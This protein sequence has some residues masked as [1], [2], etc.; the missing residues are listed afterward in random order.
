[1]TIRR[2]L[3]NLLTREGDRKKL[4][5]K[6]ARI[7]R[8]E[9]WMEPLEDRRLLDGSAEL[10]P[11][12]ISIN[13]NAGGIFNP[14]SDP[15]VNPGFDNVLAI[16]PSQLTFRF[17]GNAVLDAT[18]L[19]GIR[20][21][22][23]VDGKWDDD[24]NEV[25]VPGFRGLGET[26]RIVVTRF[27]ETLPDD[28]YRI[29]I[30]GFDDRVNGI[31]GLRDTG[32][33]LFAPTIE[34]TD[35]D[36]IY[37]KLDLGAQ[38]IAVVPQP[39]TRTTTNE[40]QQATDQIIVYFN[41]DD[42]R[43]DATSA[44]NPAFYQL[45]RT[46]DT[47]R[48]TDDARFLPDSV[49]YDPATDQAV[50]T[51]APG[52]LSEPGTYRLRIG[53]SESIPPAPTT[54]TVGEAGSSFSTAWN[55]GDLGSQSVLFS[56][57]INPQPYG[58]EFPGAIDEPGHRDIP[59]EFHFNQDRVADMQDG[60][61]PVVTYNFRTDY[62]RDPFGVTLSNAITEAQKQRA[63]E[64]FALFSQYM[65]VQFVETTGAGMTSADITIATGDLRALNQSITGG[66]G[67]PYALHGA[68][69]DT[70]GRK[71]V[72]LD[73]AELWYDGFGDDQNAATRNWFEIA[74]GEIGNIIGETT[75]LYGLGHTYDLPGKTLQ[76]QLTSGMTSAL[77]ATGEP[78]YPGDHDIVHGQY[79]FKPESN[80]IDLYQFSVASPGLF[81]VETYA[82]RLANSSSLDTCLRLYRQADDGSWELI[83]QDD[84]YFSSDSYIEYALSAGTY[85]VGV[86]ASGN[87]AYDP[88]I[89]NSGLGGRSQGPY[90][91]RLNFRPE[92][93]NA[94]VDDTGTR[95]DGDL[96]GEPGGVYNFWF[97][98]R[99]LERVLTVSWDGT[100][101]TDGQKLTLV[102]AQGVQRIFEFNSTG[103]VSGSNRSVDFTASSSAT[104]I[105][106]EL[107]AEIN[108][109]G[110]GVTARADGTDRLI[111]TG[112]R[113]ITLDETI[114]GIDVGG[115]TIFVDKLGSNDADGSLSKPFNSIGKSSAN[116][117]FANARSGDIVRIV[118]NG[119][120]DGSLATEA[121]SFAYEIGYGGPSGTTELG[122]G[123]TMNVPQ[124][125]TVMIDAGAV[126]KLSSAAI[127]VGSSTA[128]VDRSGASI[129]VL[130]TPTR[131]VFFTSY[132]NEHLGV[133]TNPV[134]TTPAAGDWGG[135][136][137]RHDVDRGQGRF[138]YETQ[139][140]FLNYINHADIRY[141]G[142]TVDVDS[143]LQT[144][145]PIRLA[146]ARP[147]LTFN[148]I[149]DSGAAAIS[150]D[151]DSFEE[152]NFHDP[153]SQRSGAFTS[154]HTRIGPQI[155]GN[156]LSGN[157]TNG[158]FVRV[159]TPAGTQLQPLTVAARFDDTDIPHVISQNLVLQ[160]TP[161]GSIYGEP[162][163]A[164]EIVTV[165]A[166]LGGK[167]APG[168]YDYKLTFVDAYGNES[169][170]SAATRSATVTAAAGQGSI[171]LENLPGAPGDFVARRL[172]RSKDGG[173]YEF[174]TQLGKSGTFYRDTGKAGGGVLGS[175]LGS[176][177]HR[178]RSDARLAIDPGTIVKL[179]SSRIEAT[180]GTQLLAEGLDGYE[181]VFTSRL[182]DRYGGSGTFDTNNDGSRTA[183][184]KGNWGGLF[185]GQGSSGSIDHALFT[186]GGGVTPVEGNFAGFN[187][188]EIHQADVRLT[189]SVIETNAD[190]RGGNAPAHRDGRGFNQAAAIFVRGAQPIIVDNIIR[191]NTG[192]AININVN[193]LNYQL[194][195]DP[196]R[197]TGPAIDRI[198]LYADNQGPLVR[199]NRLAGNS[200]NG[201]EVRGG[202]LTTQGVWDDTDITHVLRSEVIVP[203]LHTYG[204]LRLE[205]SPVES[206]VVKL[207]G[208]SAGFTAT[209]RPLDIDDRIGGAVYILGQPGFPVIL[210]SLSDD[211]VGAG[212]DPDGLPQLD[213]NGNG[214][215]S[216]T[217]GQWRGI[218]IDEFSHD[219]NVEIVLEREPADT[220]APGINATPATA[221]FLGSLAT[222]E[223]ANDDNLRLGFQIHGFLSEPGDIDVFSFSATSGTEVWFDIDRTTQALDT[224]VELI[225][226]SGNII[227]QTDNSVDETAGLYAVYEDQPSRDVNI[228]QNNGWRRKDDYTINPRDAGFRVVLP[229]TVGEV[230]TFH[231]RLRSSNL[232][233]DDPRSNL[234]D[235]SLLNEG[236]TSGVYQLQ[237]RLQQTDETPGSTVRYADIRFATVAI[238]V[239]GMPIH[240]PLLGEAVEV[241]TDNNTS[242]GAQDLG[243][244]LNTDKAA[245]SVAGS[246]TSSTDVDFYEFDVR[247]DATEVAGGNYVSTVFDVDYADG[248]ARADTSLWVFNSSGQLILRAKD[249]NIAEDRPAALNGADLDDLLRGSVGELDPFIGPIYLREGTYQVVV[250]SNAQIPQVMDQYLTSAATSP[251]I[252]LEPIDS[253]SRIAEDRMNGSGGSNIIG[254][255][256]LP[257]LFDANSPLQYHLGDIVL[258]VSSPS[259]D[260]SN[261]TT[262]RTVNPF[263]GAQVTRL[264]NFP[265]TSGDIAMRRETSDATETEGSLFTFSIASGTT[266]DDSTVQLREIDTGT[267]A[268]LASFEDG[269]TTYWDDITQAG[270]QEQTANE[271]I[272][273]EALAFAGETGLNLYAVGYRRTGLRL[274][275]PAPRNILYRFD[276]A[277]GAASSSPALNRLTGQSPSVIVV[278][279]PGNTGTQIRERGIIDT[280]AGD[281]I[282]GPGGDV[283]GLAFI[284]N[285][286]YAVS[287][288][289]GLYIV[290]PNNAATSYVQTS[291]ADLWGI[292]FEGLA[293]I[294]SRY[295]LEPGR[296]DGINLHN[297]LFAIDRRGEVYA[298]DTSGR[299]QAVF[300]DSQTHVPTGINNAQGLEFSTLTRNLWKIVTSERNTDSGHGIVAN[301]DDS[302]VAVDGN[303]SYYFGSQDGST[304]DVSDNHYDFPGGA[305]GTLIS[306]TF[307][308]EGYSAADQPMLYFNYYL[309]SEPDG[310]DYSPGSRLQR[311]AF[312]VYISGDDGN[313][314]LLGTND[315]F[316][317]R[318]QFDEFDY[319]PLDSQGRTTL[320]QHAANRVVPAVYELFQNTG[321]WRQARIPLVDYAGQKNLRLRFDFSTAGSMDVG[322]RLTTGDELRAVAGSQLRDGQTFTI[323]ALGST[324]T[325]HTFEIDLGYTLVA[326]SGAN[327]DAGDSFT[328]DP[329]GS[330]PIAARTFTFVT[331]IPGSGQIQFAPTDTPE[332]VAIRI[333]SALNSAFG[334][335]FA[336]RNDH[337]VNLVD[338]DLTTLMT[339]TA[340]G[341]PTTQYP[342]ATVAPFVEGAPD[343]DFTSSG[344]VVIHVNSGM[345]R[346]Q[347]AAAIRQ[348]L[349]DVYAVKATPEVEPN[350]SLAAAQSIE[351]AGLWTRSFN[352]DIANP[353]TYP[354]ASIAGSGNGSADYYRFT[355]TGGR[356]WVDLDDVNASMRVQLLD[357]VG[358]VLRT[359]TVAGTGG[360]VGN[361]EI[362]P[363]TVTAGQTYYVLV[364]DSAGNPVDLGER[365]TLHVSLENHTY[366]YDGAGVAANVKSEDDLVRIIK[367]EFAGQDLGPIPDAT[368]LGIDAIWAGDGTSSSLRGLPGDSFGAFTASYP[369]YAG[370]LRGMDNAHQGVWIDDVIIGLAERGEM[371]ISA[372]ANTTF[373]SNQELLNPNS[374]SSHQE[375]LT[376]PYQLEI[377]RGIE[378]GVW[379]QQNPIP[380]VQQSPLKTAPP[381]L[382]LIPNEATK[383]K[384]LNSN[385]RVAQQTTLIASPGSQI[386]DG[387]TFQLSDGVDT[388]V[389]EFE[390]GDLDNGVA[391]GHIAVVFYAADTAH[392]VAVAVR[393]A[394]N[395]QQSQAKLNIVASLSDGVAA[396]T[397]GSSNRVNLV[398]NAVPDVTGAGT[399][400]G[401]IGVEVYGLA[402]G[403]QN[404]H[405]YSGDANRLR[406]QGQLILQSNRIVASLLTGI[407]VEA[408]LRSRTDLIPRGGTLPHP[409]APINYSELNTQRLAPGVTII[410][411]V[412]AA[413]GLSGI[414]FRGDPDTQNRGAVPFGRVINNT[415]YGTG[416]GDVGIRVADQASPTLMNNILS[417]L[418]TGI[419]IDASSASTVIGA[420]LYDANVVAGTGLG[421]FAI[422]ADPLFAAP[423]LANF[424]LQAGSLAIDSS[425]DSLNDRADFATRVKAPLGIAA[426]P[427]L[428][429]SRDAMGQLRADDPTVN[430]AGPQGL[431]VFKDRGALDRADLFGPTA[432]LLN[433]RDNDS[434]G[435]DIDPSET[436]AQLVSGTLTEFSLVL[437]DGEGTGPDQMTVT[438]LQVTL[439]ED[440]RALTEG[441][442]YRYGFNPTN[443]TI[444]LTPLSG[445]WKPGR[446]YEITLN[447]R[448]RFVIVAPD[449]QT[450]KDG[451]Q[452]EITDPAGSTVVFEYESG[453]SI[454][455]PE[456]LSITIPPEGAN[457]G[458]ITDGATFQIGDGTTTV[459]FEFDSNTNAA[460]ANKVIAFKNGD[461]QDTLA[462]LV[463]QALATSGLGLSPRNLGQGKVHLGSRAIHSLT[464]PSGSVLT[465]SGTAA[466][467]EDKQSFAVVYGN[468]TRTFEFDSDPDPGNVTP[469]NIRIPFQLSQTHREIADT[470]VQVLENVN[471][472]VPAA[473]AL[474]PAHLRDGHIHLAGA[475]GYV[476]DTSASVVRQVRTS[477]RPGLITLEIPADGSGAPVGLV[478]GDRIT[479]RRGT[480]ASVTFEFDS[481]NSVPVGHVAVPFAAGES[482]ATIASRLAGAIRNNPRLG[483]DPKEL[484]GGRMEFPGMTHDLKL[485]GAGLSS[486]LAESG[487]PGVED[488]VSIAVP[489]SGAGLLDGA[490]FSIRRGLNPPV[491]FEFNLE[492]DSNWGVGNQ[493]I[494]FNPS[495]SKD[496]IAQAIVT[497]INGIPGLGLNAESV[498]DSGIVRLNETANYLLTLDLDPTKPTG[499]QRTGV[500]GGAVPVVFVPDRSFTADAMAGVIINAI[501]FSD[502]TVFARLRAGSTIFLSSP[503]AVSGIPT[504]A[505]PGDADGR[506][507]GIKDIAGNDLQ[508]NRSNNETQF[509]IVLAGAELD[510]GD[511]PSDVYPSARARDGARHVLVEDSVFLGSAVT[512]E[513]DAPTPPGADAGDD[514]VIFVDFLNAYVNSQVT[515]HA[516]GP[517]LLD[518]WIDYNQNGSWD[519]FGEKV[520]DSVALSAGSN[521]LRLQVPTFAKPGDTYA[522]FRFSV[523][524]GLFPTGI[525]VGGEVE[526]YQVTIYAGTP[527]VVYDDLVTP[528]GNEDT[529]F[530]PAYNILSNDT[531][532][533]SPWQDL[534]VAEVN[535][536]AANVGTTIT[537][538]SGA[539]LTVQAD[540]TFTFD[541]TGWAAAQQLPDSSQSI[542]QTFTYRAKDVPT[543]YPGTQLLSNNTATVTITITGLNDAPVLT[544]TSGTIPSIPEDTAQPAGT[545]VSSVVANA[546]TDVDAG[547]K[548]GMAVVGIDNSSQGRWQYT[549][550]G[551]VNWNDFAA[552]TETA[553][554]LLDDNA[555]TQIRFVPQADFNGMAT[556]RYRAW[557]QTQGT[558]GGTGD[559]SVNGGTTAFSTAIATVTVTVTPVND[560]PVLDNS[561]EMRLAAIDEDISNAANTGT[562][563]RAII[564][565]SAAN[566]GDA[567]TD[568]D[569]GDLEGI[570][571][572]GVDNSNGTWQFSIDGGAIWTDFG[573][574][575]DTSARLLDDSASTLV[576]FVPNP[577]FNGTAT[578]AL[579]AWDR[580]SGSNGDTADASNNGGTTAFSTAVET[581]SITVNPV[582]D[583]P[584]AADD[585]FQAYQGQVLNVPAP[586]VLYNDADIDGY[587]L[588]A[589]LVSGPAKG[590]LTLDPAGSFTY[591]PFASFVEGTDTFTYQAQGNPPGGLL[592]NVATVTITMNGA[593]VAVGE[594]YTTAEDTALDVPAPGIL[595][596]D[597]DPDNDDLVAVLVQPPSHGQ[598]QQ[599]LN[600]GG[601][602]NGGF[603]YTPNQ[604]FHGTDT[605]T[606]KANDGAADSPVAT[607]TI[608]VSPVNDAPV[609]TPDTYLAWL[610]PGNRLQIAAPGVLGNDVDVDGDP[611]QARLVANSGPQLG[612]LTFNADGSFTYTAG[613]DFRGLDSFQYEALDPSGLSSGPVL[614]TI[615]GSSWHN[616]TL[617]AD[618]NGDGRVSPID[619]LQAINRLNRFGPGPLPLPATPPPYYDVNGDGNLTA[620]DAL[621][622]INIL[623]R[624]SSGSGEGE[625]GG[626]PQR[627]AAEG[628]SVAVVGVLAN[629]DRLLT[630]RLRTAS[631]VARPATSLAGA[632]DAV[633]AEV[634]DELLA[635]PAALAGSAPAP[636][637]SAGSGSEDLADELFPVLANSHSGSA[638]AD[639]IDQAIAGLFG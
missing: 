224:V 440:G 468:Q 338:P 454:Y 402:P 605:F 167:L 39:V 522:R 517:G 526:D 503:T 296:S 318:S 253:V 230:G 527:P 345:N 206:L 1:M 608:T 326:P 355:G 118:G 515:V 65:G 405:G 145:D 397:A 513:T 158:L 421:S 333:A 264:G 77:S 374:P 502:S 615:Q 619:A 28:L 99:P 441:V 7:A 482:A 222:G 255:S 75:G 217:P 12:L 171:L 611:L 215:S 457:P 352:Q 385:D 499:L 8:R 157:S 342:A 388:I 433:P 404:E 546:V 55:L 444:L 60:T 518:A 54:V 406:Q 555:W 209:G 353:L 587:G 467:I 377:R 115:R 557:D 407:D 392:E 428:A 303:A 221:Q 113:K 597:S 172:Y 160:G 152:T 139:D 448:D 236:L 165:N 539:K 561:G 270:I 582:A 371:V 359:A 49:S 462:N 156:R 262:V 577:N 109:A 393:D 505:G 48:N 455:V 510:Y 199:A 228:L 414:E 477:G 412:I 128:S 380:V 399:N 453:Y 169:P 155:R 122:D 4:L 486:Q 91:V 193:A 327:I 354:H 551:G 92:V 51:F 514:G 19:D 108:A 302:R 473:L 437:V 86:S 595:D 623:N 607:V 101:F 382:Q 301:H 98:T 334:S 200:I 110:F 96:D 439:T 89:P 288:A 33:N 210:T 311:D 429:P 520:F 563:V 80:D 401:S 603:T 591:T 578:I 272:V 244:L 506:L 295:A 497:V 509:T 618:V 191:N 624:M 556:L 294:D 366:T 320:S 166:R 598:L 445:I 629:P 279:G 343:L 261:S 79:L 430:N 149:R 625:A 259:P 184:A 163:P 585:A 337:R 140:I 570:A 174:V 29:E 226:A 258:F 451:D 205:S 219:R 62:G 487:E 481:N 162:S 588:T 265:Y 315:S 442:D 116:N 386:A 310:N 63:R 187:V 350:D 238:D 168:T 612:T 292:E 120:I 344:N 340:V 305:H 268:V 83:A 631:S 87:D 375:I 300:A 245:L 423:G 3:R 525:A 307:S 452:F 476:V 254:A 103:G 411:N 362:G 6:R 46:Q 153:P 178:P 252:R 102:D 461:S 379:P 197:S 545:T 391:P 417:N 600:G 188:L 37:F 173:A 635:A 275:D 114:V 2:S 249:S 425:L 286:L 408:G 348:R 373:I 574:P 475:W 630:S 136:F 435:R 20:I 347:V 57:Q 422:V 323:N 180:M 549:L 314:T 10:G 480:V 415:I 88:T 45:I 622:V 306:N 202:I 23:S 356:V 13:P 365:Y 485:T 143:V 626:Q 176:L 58:L 521:D 426:S 531:D 566:G 512:S 223:K 52:V 579:R 229:G 67:Y 164:I 313:W 43:D 369:S 478:D 376:G 154:D 287:D 220:S 632:T 483:I 492:T 329:D 339:V 554:R 409:G 446:T 583:A 507:D 621:L 250:T 73:N 542:N 370:S 396:G 432:R 564:D 248:I 132:K 398:G 568:V 449:G 93:A 186:F 447:N 516:S 235:P 565:S 134:P 42:L 403:F 38:V 148:Y 488:A 341:L 346:N 76:G 105:R 247:Y 5:R 332:Q 212:F 558:S 589:V 420:N 291:A 639:A 32:G 360:D 257:V 602:W 26:P 330:G 494:L 427:I 544:S 361:P 216:G 616:Y 104:A 74:M 567:I 496:A 364:T 571:V 290:N 484:G 141:G 317:S 351:S 572:I 465:Q 534:T 450:A 472:S 117:A 24:N 636:S 218:L 64:I 159:D 363:Y 107:V 536:D 464:I 85:I 436:V 282:S 179:E 474:D 260:A 413:S 594:S 553:A 523:G 418:A 434:E 584:V 146:K 524:G 424:Y 390:D 281:I 194:V 66:S 309:D 308:L 30:F 560:A 190:G 144:V 316:Q 443:R 112:E 637:S 119:G 378:Y 493:P 530:E 532:A 312:R 256:S 548:K 324:S 469:G 606:Y 204:G 368:R 129:Q 35:R 227:A 17:D 511:A 47:A 617:P 285:T 207:Q 394:I 175:A 540:G 501:N 289:G 147:T 231:V 460:P 387:Q 325:Q 575:S 331:G 349:A 599:H 242:A 84:D 576:R 100:A 463:V 569:A 225:D 123:A 614:V 170:A 550:D 519:D 34:G 293:T 562:S 11:R 90:D 130:G 276:A 70:F 36:T 358:T 613:A 237:I 246:L 150:A 384:A 498:K 183:P 328:V 234:H 106:D 336:V 240:S 181:V 284:G 277:S 72:I 573:S 14:D 458:G 489:A 15:G 71:T 44:E 383:S 559:A 27:A 25:I 495:M 82:E 416:I 125:I 638:I 372:P 580:T 59:F 541:P 142:G 21:T 592:S 127:I 266:I 213:T 201:M 133:D 628:E 547:A 196:G 321:T 56:A 50:L 161:G 182:D 192:A 593:P 471:A 31:Q 620:L 609:G 274:G 41:N 400:F 95:F 241:T 410:N 367:H 438:T 137:I 138:V 538:P 68:T 195:T 121:D 298:F 198:T 135:I 633:F 280:G 233:A 40:L 456:R 18:T 297:L 590:T 319:G 263:T 81:T 535:G 389:F 604:D 581:A 395:S 627:Q 335:G 357:S 16:A 273:F 189:S 500:E 479:I 491:I 9:L 490:T 94:I 470:I 69:P 208:A 151:P 537:L 232:N 586:G 278:A 61:I 269:I 78:I 504:I 111:L 203:D 508:P 304:G 53:T 124:G 634:A 381:R 185:F 22:R 243:N 239:Q 177:I 459:T 431:N 528:A 601:S 214:P 552:P 529:L 466:G 97:Q 267:A 419:S 533:E 283:T 299:L 596:N 610:L 126:F 251:L 131:S 271:G 211:S 543:V 322:N